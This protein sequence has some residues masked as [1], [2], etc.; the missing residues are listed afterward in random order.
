MF[1][2]LMGLLLLGLGI[3]SPM[4][5]SVKGETTENVQPITTPSAE[6]SKEDREKIN[7]HIRELRDTAKKDRDAYKAVLKNTKDAFKA[8]VEAS[9]TAYKESL[10]TVRE[11]FGEEIKAKHEESVSESKEKREA[12]FQKLQTI[13]DEKKK[14]LTGDLQNRITV[15]NVR[16][17][18]AMTGHLIKMSEILE[19]IL[20]KVSQLK[21]SSINTSAVETA[22]TAADAAI[23]AAQAAVAAQ[24][25]KPYLATLTTE[26]NV[27]NDVVAMMKTLEADLKVTTQLEAAARKAVSTA[28]QELAKAKKETVPAAVVN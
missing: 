28:I 19:N 12:F 17:T 25:G 20:G 14:K 24:A 13:K 21:A 8:N 5:P 16:R 26:T 6:H 18:D 22:V 11:T 1:D 3:Q 4:T 10:R 23:T 15:L 27:R 2:H 9:R 7:A